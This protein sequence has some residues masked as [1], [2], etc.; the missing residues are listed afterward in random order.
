M[1]PPMAKFALVVL[2]SASAALRAEEGPADPAET[3]RE[4]ITLKQRFVPGSYVVTE[5]MDMRQELLTEG[6]EIPSQRVSQTI[7]STRKIGERDSKGRRKVV[8]AFKTMKQR[9]D[10]GKVTISFDSEGVPAD[11]DPNLSAVFDALKDVRIVASVAPEGEILDS[12]GMDQVW[13]RLAEQAPA[14]APM[15]NQMKKH[16]TDGMIRRL[17]RGPADMLPAKPVALGEKW[18]AEA[19]FEMPFGGQMTCKHDC[20]LE[21]VQNTSS[22]RIAIVRF[23]GDHQVGEGS[24]IRLGG[25]I[26]KVLKMKFSQSGQIRLNVDTGVIA[27]HSVGGVGETVVSITT[28]DGQ[29]AEMKFKQEMTGECI[30]RPEAGSDTG[31][32]TKR[33]N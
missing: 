24:S 13:D 22:G 26:L 30:V 8:I 10:V 19:K 29:A 31:A 32:S 15:L 7:V 16:V 6:A 28:D 21:E 33:E 20:V 9:L 5:T 11:Q 27:S 12:T 4:K 2:I 18:Q 25:T 1:K 17:I 23:S 14:A 3:S